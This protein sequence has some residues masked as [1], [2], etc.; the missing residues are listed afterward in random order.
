MGIF[1]E[2]SPNE[3]DQTF[4]SLGQVELPGSKAAGYRETTG[5]GGQIGQEPESTFSAELR[6]LESRARHSERRLRSHV[7]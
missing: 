7:G 6:K 5:S 3:L 1:D 2:E 4:L